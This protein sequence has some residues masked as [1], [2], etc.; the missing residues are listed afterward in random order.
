VGLCVGQDFR[1]D[2]HDF[3]SHHRKIRRPDEL[4]ASR[5][6]PDCSELEHFSREFAAG[7]QDDWCWMERERLRSALAE[8]L[9]VLLDAAE[10]RQLWQDVLEYGHR[11]LKQEPLLESVHQSMLRAHL[12]MGNKDAALRQF[13]GLTRR[14]Q[15]EL[16][17]TPAPQTLHL[18]RGTVHGGRQSAQAS[19]AGSA[20]DP[21]GIASDREPASAEQLIERALRHVATAEKLLEAARLQK[22]L[23]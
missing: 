17:A 11:L 7:I 21:A 8:L 19:P 5:L 2:V 12:A 4:W 10:S 15:R 1:S 23:P 20:S 9:T 6:Q 14:L 18:I 13:R 3:E 16:H 22:T